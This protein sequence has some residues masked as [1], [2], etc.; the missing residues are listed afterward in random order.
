M[1]ELTQRAGEANAKLVLVGDGSQLQAINAGKAFRIIYE[2]DVCDTTDMRDILRQKHENLRKAVE[3]TVFGDIGKAVE[4]LEDNIVEKKRTS[5]RHVQISN[6]YTNRSKEERDKTLVL[7]ATN[8]DR[9]Q[10]NAYIRDSLRKKGEIGKTGFTFNVKNNRDVESEKSF[11]E[12]D[13]VVFLNNDRAL[14]VKN[15][16]MGEVLDIHRSG[17]ISIQTE[18]GVKNFNINKN[19]NWIDHGYALTNYKA[20]GQTTKSVLINLD[21]AK[22][23]LTNRNSFYVSI[24]RATDEVKIYTNDK[25]GLVNSLRTWQEKTTTYDLR[26]PEQEQEKGIDIQNIKKEVK[27]ILS[28]LEKG[29]E[30][31]ELAET[32][33]EVDHQLQGT[34]MSQEVSMTEKVAP[35]AEK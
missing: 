21:T 16:T 14:G 15:G 27:N 4:K 24:S 9:E 34:E 30:E 19:Y 11:S 17:D 32:M 8:K 29:K 22:R 20:Q 1:L 18:K 10:I 5:N 3:Q 2:K 33:K 26:K 13:K 31:P 25:E 35:V 28:S 12:R 23:S 7:T 6:D